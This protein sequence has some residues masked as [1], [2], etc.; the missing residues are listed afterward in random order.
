MI[1]EERRE[2]RRHILGRCLLSRADVRGK[3]FVSEDV[4]KSISSCA[5]TY[6]GHV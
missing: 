2:E 6:L 4:I 3:Q 5:D 1:R